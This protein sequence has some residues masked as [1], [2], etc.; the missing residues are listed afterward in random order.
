[1]QSVHT[2]PYL[3][4]LRTMN[5]VDVSVLM[6]NWRLFDIR[7]TREQEAG[8]RSAKV[9]HHNFGYDHKGNCADGPVA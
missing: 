4:E 8:A 5:D 9:A 6:P 7:V 2:R 3:T 1:M